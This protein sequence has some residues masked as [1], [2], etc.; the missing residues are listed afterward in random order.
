MALC[1]IRAEITALCIGS[2]F[3]CVNVMC[4]AELL[5]TGVA[6]SPAHE[7]KT[8]AAVSSKLPHTLANRM[9]FVGKAQRSRIVHDQGPTLER[10]RRYLVAVCPILRDNNLFLW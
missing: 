3:R 8:K 4:P 2:K 5:K 9:L 7:H 10:M 6:C 1:Q